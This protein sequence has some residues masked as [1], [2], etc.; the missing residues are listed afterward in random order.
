[1]QT[2]LAAPPSPQGS[3]E[4]AEKEEGGTAGQCVNS[5]LLLDAQLSCFQISNTSQSGSVNV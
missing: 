3:T 5:N 2:S 1:M 4:L